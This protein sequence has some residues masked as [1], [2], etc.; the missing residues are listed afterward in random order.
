MGEVGVVTASSSGEGLK[1][2]TLLSCTERLL[3]SNLPTWPGPAGLSGPTCQCGM[4][5]FK[6]R[7][8]VCFNMDGNHESAFK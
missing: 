8:G 7:R 3:S 1:E 2:S 6:D 4:F 5:F